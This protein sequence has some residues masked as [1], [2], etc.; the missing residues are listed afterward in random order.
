[1]DGFGEKTSSSASVP[2]SLQA[3]A[4]AYFKPYAAV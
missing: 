1:M 4:L 2:F 3:M